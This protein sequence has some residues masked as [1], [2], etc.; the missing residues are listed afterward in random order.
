MATL[1]ERRIREILNRYD[2][3]AS[4]RSVW[5]IKQSNA[6]VIRSEVLQRIAPKAGI[7]WGPMTVLRA[8]RDEAVILVQASRQMAPNPQTGEILTRTEWSIGEAHVGVNYKVSGNQAA[9]VWAMAEKR[10]KDRVILR[11]LELDDVAQ[12]SSAPLE[13]GEDAREPLVDRDDDDEPPKVEEPPRTS[14]TPPPAPPPPA[15]ADLE[16]WQRPPV[17]TDPPK[18]KIK[19]MIKRATSSNDLDELFNKPNVKT[20]LG[21]MNERDQEEIKRFTAAH[22]ATLAPAE[23]PEEPPRS[24]SVVDPDPMALSNLTTLPT[25]ISKLIEPA[26]DVDDVDFLVEEGL[27]DTPFEDLPPQI[28]D[29]IIQVI[30]ARKEFIAAKR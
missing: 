22:E 14:E 21:K 20:A 29:Q 3:E 15:E 16:D 10:A 9:Y 8:E 24:T 1:E 13:L 5:R 30:R 12:G 7:T 23:T 17:N 2:E 28:K 18:V 11:L 27:A 25:R 19:R 26:E 6:P 4:K